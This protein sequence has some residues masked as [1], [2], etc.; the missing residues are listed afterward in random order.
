MEELMTVLKKVLVMDVEDYRE[1]Y[2][3]GDKFKASREIKK[4]VEEGIVRTAGHP[5]DGRKRCMILTMKGARELG[6]DVETSRQ[7]IKKEQ[8]GWGIAK[9]KLYFRIGQAGIPANN[10]LSRK[11]ALE[12]YNL[13]ANETILAWV[14]EE[15]GPYALY[16]PWKTRYKGW[17]MQSIN[18]TE[19]QTKVFKGHILVHETKERWRQDRRRFL[20]G[21][22]AGQFYLMTYE[23]LGLMKKGPGE[24]MR[25]V[26]EM[27]QAIA[28]GGE[29]KAAL[30][31]TPLDMVYERRGEMLV[32]DMR[33]EDITLAARVLNLTNERLR[34]YNGV[35][36]VMRD[37]A[38]VKEWARVFGCWNKLWYLAETTLSL[39]RYDGKRLQVVGGKKHERIA[40]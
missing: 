19:G 36:L 24:M 38:Q 3:E 31:G 12:K 39:Y 27:F 20:N 17:I 18:K 10:L 2:C 8:L 34:G 1:M 4:L 29:L 11:D 30:P 37:E 16:V 23:H 26:E 28:P 13:R 40:Q 5:E 33:M 15:P 22:P 35:T 25:E 32:G 14:I 6:L 21:S 9:S 7:V